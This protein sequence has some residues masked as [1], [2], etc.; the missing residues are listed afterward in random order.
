MLMVPAFI[1]TL[2][3]WTPDRGM[4]G[5]AALAIFLAACATDGL[6][7]WI[8]RRTGQK[9]RLGSLLDPMADKI[10]LTSAYLALAWLP[11]IPDGARLPAWLAV[12]VLSR[13]IML[14]TGTAVI[15]I[16][17]NRFEAKTNFLGKLTTVLQ[18][19]LIVASLAGAPEELI[20][21]M[22]I[23][24]AAAT[25]LSGVVYLRFGSARLGG[26]TEHA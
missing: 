12:V 24:V 18:M 26:G 25:A 17:Q 21:V 20:Q 11:S 3:Y 7:G 15:F 5:I 10:L 2:L 22:V 13:D 23:T 4:L 9:T 8:A 6:D 1:T 14:V 16:M 19:A